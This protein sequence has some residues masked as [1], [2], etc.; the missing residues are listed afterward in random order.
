MDYK[1]GLWLLWITSQACS[2]CGLQARLVAA[3]DYKLPKDSSM[4]FK[5][6][7]AVKFHTA[8]KSHMAAESYMAAESHMANMTSA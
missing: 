5:S 2:C 3:V 4:D 1:P 6:H 7:T 8:V